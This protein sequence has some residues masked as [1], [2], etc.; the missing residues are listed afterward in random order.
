VTLGGFRRGSKIVF[1]QQQRNFRD[2]VDA[3]QNNYEPRVKLDD[4]AIES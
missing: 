4:V 2:V 1:D 3:T